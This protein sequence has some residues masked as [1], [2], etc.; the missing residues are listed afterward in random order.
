MS[1]ILIIEDEAV[2]RTA[3][4]RLLERRGHSVVE[5]DSV[6]SARQ[7]DLHQFNLVLSDLRLPKAPGTDIIPA[8]SDTPVIIM[9]SYASVPSAVDAMKRGAVDYIAK[10][11][12][13]DELLMLI[14]RVLKQGKVERQR[15]A[16]KHDVAQA[17][18]VAGMVGKCAAM[19]EVREHIER[20]APTEA[21]VLILGE[22]G[23]GKELVARA[24]H[25]K[26][27][28]HNAPFVA[29]NCAA[30]PEH[31]I[32]TELFGLDQAGD[33]E[34][35]GLMD[36]A[37]GGTLFLDE[38]GELPLPAQARILR[39]LQG[40]EHRER[41]THLRK[42]LDVRILA[43]THRDI[44]QLVRENAF[45]NDLYF[46]LR[47]VEMSLP[48]LRERGDDVIELAVYLLEKTCKQLNRPPLRLA[49]ESLEAIRRYHW[50]GNVRELENTIERAVILCEGDIISPV[51]LAIDH[52]IA[53]TDPASTDID[54]QLSLEEYFR[55]FVLAHQDHLTE[56]ELAH[57]LGISRKALWER[58]QRFGI[59][60]SKKS[61]R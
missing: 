59:P 43:A 13:H 8:V 40:G 6:E 58:R 60:R 61:R 14:D 24:L 38:V 53:H 29:F 1:R 32:E 30:V 23:T 33:H 10:P 11:F 21:T 39:V 48:P 2:I 41:S 7:E 27:R 4:R 18:P 19:V 31:L 20:V 22:S 9:T 28:R 37:D 25:E 26:S 54:N 52:R 34:R 5:A 45:R 42:P 55:Q 50:P 15:Q 49:R 57:R 51:L 3:L 44:H 36:R 12:D 16:L 46:R 56:T 35:G 47:V 17:Y